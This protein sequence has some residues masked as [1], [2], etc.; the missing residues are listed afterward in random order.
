MFQ[1]FFDESADDP[2]EQALIMAGWVSDVTTWR[3]FTAAWK[4]VLDAAPRIDYFK[5]HEAMSLSEQFEGWLPLDR[6]KK[7]RELTQ[8]VC[9]HRL[10]Y[11]VVTTF[12][13]DSYKSLIKGWIPPQRQLK[14]IP[15]IK[16]PYPICFHTTIASVLQ[17]QV[18]RGTT[19]QVDFVFDSRTDALKKCIS[20][21]RKAKPKIR[22]Q[23][24]KDIAGNASAAD[25][26]AV[27][28]LQT[29]DLLAGQYLATIRTNKNASYL[30][31]LAT[32]HTIFENKVGP[33]DLV[34]IRAAL[35]IT[36]LVR[37]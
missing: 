25:D 18:S 15:F 11:G 5:H 16:S 22:T 3:S 9:A 8:V 6:D 30:N 28:P 37:E 33:S 10:A 23:A 19:E 26:K 14:A 17:Q 29:A 34:G 12:E 7:L 21:F 20:Q 13:H 4:R 31:K 27:L 2:R 35:R 24:I 32:H 1:A 36:G